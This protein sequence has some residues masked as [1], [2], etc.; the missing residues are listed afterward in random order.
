MLTGKS[1]A[2]FKL[3]GAFDFASPFVNEW[4]DSAPDDSFAG[5]L[6]S[7]LIHIPVVYSV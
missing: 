5:L 7:L 6:H 1:E 3:L 4:A 2:M